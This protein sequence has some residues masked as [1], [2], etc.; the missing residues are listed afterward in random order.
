MT[1]L[2]WD[3][4]G[5]K[6][7]EIGVDHGVLYIPTAGVYDQGFAWNGLTTVTE[8]PSGAEPQPQYADNIKYINLLSYE[9]FGGTIEAYTYPDEWA[10]CDGSAEPQVGVRVGQ[11]NRVTFGLSYRTKIGNDTD[12]MDSGYKI[13]LVWAALAAASE[14]AY[15]TVNDSPEP[16][17]F[18]W[19]FT[20]TP[21]EVVGYPNLKPT[22][23]ICVDSTKVD[24]TAL[25]ALELVLYGSIGVDPKLPAP[26]EVLDMFD[27]T[28]T[29][30]TAANA[31]YNTGTHVVTIPSTTGVKY[32]VNG[33]EATAGAQAAM[34]VGQ[35]SHVTAVAQSGYVLSANSDDDWVF[36]Y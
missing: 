16:I 28:V 13:H 9:E 1:K 21:V 29:T 31:T 35:V 14:R 6:K 18:S 22:S 19:D 5:E 10:Q 24:S 30:V 23:Y 3:Q 27:G 17:N 36:P 11:Q 26:G 33:V 12:G 25:T 32:Y 7:Y 34:T 15:E 2:L 20:T 4:T 8:S